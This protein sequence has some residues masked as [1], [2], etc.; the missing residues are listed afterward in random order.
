MR[1]RERERE[2]E[3]ERGRSSR[4]EA[5]VDFLALTALSGL[6]LYILRHLIS[7]WSGWKCDKYSRLDSTALVGC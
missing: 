7:A 6:V 1:K 2:R 3:R 4:R 5:A